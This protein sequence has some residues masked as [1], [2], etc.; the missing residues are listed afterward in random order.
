TLCF[1]PYF[2]SAAF[3]CKRVCLKS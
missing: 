3:W 2:L 1:T